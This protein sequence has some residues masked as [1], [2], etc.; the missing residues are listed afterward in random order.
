MDMQILDH[1]RRRCRL[2]L[3][4]ERQQSFIRAAECIAQADA[5]VTPRVSTGR[6]SVLPTVTPTEAASSAMWLCRLAEAIASLDPSK[7]TLAVPAVARKS[8]T[9]ARNS[10]SSSAAALHAPYAW[11]PSSAIA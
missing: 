3:R 10:G 7:V 4:D 8:A 6:L 11:L 2:E 1:Q 5:A 9:R